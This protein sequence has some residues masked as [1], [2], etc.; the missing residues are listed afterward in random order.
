MAN[1]L[2]CPLST[3][4]DL[5]NHGAWF[6]EKNLQQKTLQTTFVMFDYSHKL[7]QK[8]HKAFVLLN[9]IFYISSNEKV[10]VENAIFFYMN[11][12]II[13]QLHANEYK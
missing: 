11:I 10:N 13:R 7:I 4:T 3:T 6:C 8:L 9:S 5:P 2:I 1:D 12:R